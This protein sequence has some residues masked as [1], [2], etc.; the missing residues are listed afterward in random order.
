MNFP[1]EPSLR[2][3]IGELV[4]LYAQRYRTPAP[5]VPGQAAAPP[6]QERLSAVPNSAP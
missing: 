5:F 4:A 6:P 3:H 2:Q 1:D